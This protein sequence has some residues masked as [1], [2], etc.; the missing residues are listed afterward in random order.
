MAATNMRVGVIGTGFGRRVVAPVFTETEGCEV[1]DVVSPRDDAT[2][3][4]LCARDDVDLISVHSP[5]FLHAANV[6][7]ALA[8]GRAVLCDKPFAMNADE[9]RSLLDEA[10]SAGVI[11]LLN[12][13]FRRHPARRKARE[14]VRSGIIGDVEHVSWLSYSAGSR[15]PMRRF[16][17]LFQ[18][19]TGGGWIGAWASHA[20]D[21]IRWIF[22]EVTAAQASL[23]TGVRERPDR[24]GGMHACDAEDGFTASLTLE[25]G[26]TVCIDTTFVAPAEM[27]SRMTILGSE[28]AMEWVGDRHITIRRADGSRE[29]FELETPTDRDPHLVPMRAWAADVRD[30]VHDQRQ[31]EPSFAD[32]VACDLVLDML[33]AGVR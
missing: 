25:S 19:E 26:A 13:E 1:V 22:G 29:Q 32:G 23:R 16:G 27:P 33:R 28:G 18:R 20:I 31:I 2:V 11:H 8:S 24:E 3:K 4:E 10:T 21:S 9:A 17:W 14:L 6:R 7:S 30:A 12:F 5:P 15:R